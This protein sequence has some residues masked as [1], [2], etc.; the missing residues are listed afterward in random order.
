MEIYAFFVTCE[1]KSLII[2]MEDCHRKNEEIQDQDRPAGFQHD[3]RNR[4]LQKIK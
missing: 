3:M 2:E 1:L 4:D